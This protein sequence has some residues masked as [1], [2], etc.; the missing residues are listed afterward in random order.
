MLF[1][2]G[3]G[4]ELEGCYN[5]DFSCGVVIN[6]ENYMDYNYD[7]KKMFIQGQVEWMVVVLYLF[8]CMFLWLEENLMVIG[9]VDLVNIENLIFGE[10]QVF[11]NLVVDCVELCFMEVL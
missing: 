4:I 6:G 3:L 1:I 10:F 7:C 9:C 8:F 5:N 11:F 2:I